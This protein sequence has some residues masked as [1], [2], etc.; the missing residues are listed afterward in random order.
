MAIAGLNLNLLELTQRRADIENEIS[1]LQ[2]QKN[3]SLYSQHDKQA[4]QYH[5]IA[6]ARR[7]YKEQFQILDHD[8]D[9]KYESY[10]E[11][12]E[13]KEMIDLISAKYQDELAEIEAWE[14]Q[15]DTQ[16]TTKSA[17]LEEVKA[18]EES[19]KSMLQSNIQSDFQFGLNQ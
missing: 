19:Y 15:I 13:Y 10:E 17:E 16:I 2:S 5:E 14:T 8:E 6:D 7:Y 11:M 9:C 12:P 18:W 1:Y 4:L 3:L